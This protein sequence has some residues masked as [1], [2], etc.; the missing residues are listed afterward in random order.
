MFDRVL[1]TPLK[2]AVMKAVNSWLKTSGNNARERHPSSWKYFSCWDL[3]CWI[4]QPLIQRFPHLF[5]RAINT[6][7]SIYHYEIIVY[8]DLCNSLIEIMEKLKLIQNNSNIFIRNVWKIFNEELW[9]S[10]AKIGIVSFN[11][12]GVEI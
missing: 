12:I 1:N 7:R 3:Y 10:S 5:L 6:K 4:N 2:K 9:L 11:W 8:R